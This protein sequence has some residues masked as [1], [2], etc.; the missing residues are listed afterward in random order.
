LDPELTLTQPARVTALTG[1]DALAHAVETAVTKTR[2][3]LS[4]AFSREAWRHLAPN[5]LRVIRHAD[6]VEARGE[7]QLGACLAGLAIENSMLGAGH[8][9]ANPLTATFDVS[10]GEAVALML[11]HVVRHNGAAV[12]GWY[13]DLLLTTAHDRDCPDP[14]GGAAG[15]AHFLRQT[16]SEAGLAA[17]LRD[18][19]VQR[20]RL[21]QLAA[22]AT[23]QWTGTFNPVEMSEVD[24]LALY[25]TAF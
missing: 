10:H 18:A 23:K 12:D 7:M 16:A 17:R 4:L 11:P 24:F 1:F 19:G 6:D 15:L 3:P 22:D 21:P 25:E 13:Q 5:Y 20:D 8:A 2:T 14:R 9:L